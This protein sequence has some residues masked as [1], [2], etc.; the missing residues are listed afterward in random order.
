M[1]LP[2]RATEPDNGRASAARRKE[3]VAPA[4]TAI[5]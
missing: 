2:D 5:G 1:S 3:G 4:H